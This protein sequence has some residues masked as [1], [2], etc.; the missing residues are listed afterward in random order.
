MRLNKRVQRLVDGVDS[1]SLRNNTQRVL[2]QMLRQDSEWVS[3]SSIRVPS[4]TARLRD[5]R[6]EEFGGFTVECATAS[7]LERAG[8]SR[9]TFYRL[10][11]RSVTVERV[12]RVLGS[13]VR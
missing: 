6:K 13:D 2:V 1:R 8:D 11:P 12:E 3:R 7:E 10:D 4:A 5:L 9:R